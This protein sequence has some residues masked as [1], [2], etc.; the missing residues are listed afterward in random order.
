MGGMCARDNISCM[1][2]L[3]LPATDVG[4]S[5]VHYWKTSTSHV[6]VLGFTATDVRKSSIHYWESRRSHV[7]V[8]GLTATDVGK[9]SIHM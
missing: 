2:F 8:L 3:R 1:V 6:S 5:S 4:K 7:S 9:S